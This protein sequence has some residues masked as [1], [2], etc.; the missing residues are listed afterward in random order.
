[1]ALIKYGPAGKGQRAGEGERTVGSEMLSGEGRGRVV[2][3]LLSS[4]EEGI[5]I[6]QITALFS[7]AP[8]LPP[9][10]EHQDGWP[11][12]VGEEWRVAATP[13]TFTY[14]QAA[15]YVPWTRSI[16]FVSLREHGA[17]DLNGIAQVVFVVGCCEQ[18][19]S[20]RLSRTRFRRNGDDC[21]GVIGGE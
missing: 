1:M 19:P 5:A 4:R 16:A 17:S 20:R 7:P 2:S 8:G 11:D 14:V 10:E 21:W 9:A 6:T 3:W 18:A 13:G 12:P 15:C